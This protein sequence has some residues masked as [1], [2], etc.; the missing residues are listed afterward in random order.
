[1]DQ[2]TLVPVAAFASCLQS[3]AGSGALPNGWTRLSESSLRAAGQVMSRSP[4]SSGMVDIRLALVALIAT[5]VPTMPTPT[6]LGKM[7]A[8][9]AAACAGRGTCGTSLSMPAS[10]FARAHLWFQDDGDAEATASLR[11]AVLKAWTGDDGRVSCTDLLLDVCCTPGGDSG[12]GTG[13]SASILDGTVGDGGDEHATCL[14][15]RAAARA[16]DGRLATMGTQNG[17]ER[18]GFTP[19]PQRPSVVE[20]RVHTLRVHAAAEL[21]RDVLH[22]RVPWVGVLL[23]ARRQ[24]CQLFRAEALLGAKNA[25]TLHGGGRGS[26][27]GVAGFA[28]TAVAEP[29]AHPLF[30]VVGDSSELAV[31]LGV[32]VPKACTPPRHTLQS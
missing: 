12:A 31:A 19:P 10:A 13:A 21:R 28:G 30:A 4:A 11:A 17:L 32:W 3:L 18:L 8:S 15:V 25:R 23:K 22:L 5:V 14:S 7:V 27:T 6:A 9:L 1:M 20:P 2:P 16:R 29:H 26:G 24:H